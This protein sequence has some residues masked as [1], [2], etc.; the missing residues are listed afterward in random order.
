MPHSASA[1]V[2]HACAC[3]PR[4]LSCVSQPSSESGTRRLPMSCDRSDAERR[5]AGVGG[6]VLGVIARRM[7][8]PGECNMSKIERCSL[9]R[10]R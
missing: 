8:A 9:G 10:L 7:E 5:L 1:A 6:E 4:A 3:R 2:P